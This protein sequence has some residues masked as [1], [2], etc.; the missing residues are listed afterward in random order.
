MTNG[1]SILLLNSNP[2]FSN[3][4][5]AKT[6]FTLTPKTDERQGIS[7]RSRKSVKIYSK[8]LW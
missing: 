5:I 7:E 4:K 6:P 2:A 3:I 1:I 8:F